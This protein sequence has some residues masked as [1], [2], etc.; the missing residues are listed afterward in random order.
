MWRCRRATLPIYVLL[1]A[2]AGNPAPG[3]AALP[4]LA[5]GS[6][7]YSSGGPARVV[8]P[9]SLNAESELAAAARLMRRGQWEQS[10]PILQALLES[11]GHRV[12]R[13]GGGYVPVADLVNRRLASAPEAAQR[14]CNLL[15]GPLAE[16]LY[17]EAVSKRSAPMLADVARRYLNTR[18]GPLAVSALASL[19]MDEGRPGSALI[20]LR[21]ADILRLDAAAAKPIAAKKLICLARLN[22]RE[23]AERLVRNLREDGITHLTV[24]GIEW[25][26]EA[27]LRDAFAR[28][29]PLAPPAPQNTWSVLGGSA[30][31]SRAPAL[32][33]PDALFPLSTSLPWPGRAE[34]D[35]PSLPSTR[36]VASKGALFV[37]RDGTIFALD[38][39]S[40][41]AKWVALA[42]ETAPELLFGL[43][44][45]EP[46]HGE[47]LAGYLGM[48]NVHRWRTF[49]NHGL[50]TVSVSEG[51]LFAIR[52]DPLRLRIPAKPWAARPAEVELANGLSC[53]DAEHG[54][55]LWRLGGGTLHSKGPL[56]E[57]WF[58]T[59]PTVSH[60]QAYV[61][62][63]R[64]GHLYALCL[65]AASGRL[66]W[67]SRIGALEARQ[68][69][70]RYAMQFFLADTAPPAVADGIAI[71]PT[72]Q[73]LVCAYDARDGSL[74][75]VA[76][77]P[78]ADVWISRLGERINVPAGPWHP[79][80]P[81]L[82]GGLCLLTPMDSRHLVAFSI[83]T[84]G[85][86]WQA[87]FPHGT[88]LLGALDDHTYVQNAGVTCLDLRSG[89]AVWE[90]AEASR[91]VGIGALGRE[92][93][94]VPE[95]TG[96]RRLHVSSGEEQ[97]ALPWPPGAGTAGNL[98]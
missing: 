92:V 83:R 46:P 89:E 72:G 55:V 57:C 7:D 31:G 8:L 40:L 85:A 20:A 24:G 61:L 13:D 70:Q 4:V 65:D 17:Q 48:G 44:E 78:R 37:N 45:H 15:Y 1:A 64:R 2:V 41:R 77:Y 95:R 18:F 80:Q 97:D 28:L 43:V 52:V 63:A 47:Y 73:G 69:V 6:D 11:E 42:P 38:R 29:G 74:L 75:W 27:L 50:A 71:F 25:E 60:G 59:A 33:A 19:L 34:P 88:A 62:A 22:R 32:F 82:Q 51:R 5:N 96:I 16:R 81:L 68:E 36:P 53:Y 94:Y 21:R 91:P 67:R 39:R 49:D 87:E 10:L 9:L 84:G 79:R 58:F 90:V 56:D 35:V 86:V 23:D 30:A 12:I 93:V 76:E 54:S 26:A 98:L 66:I 3:R 14:V